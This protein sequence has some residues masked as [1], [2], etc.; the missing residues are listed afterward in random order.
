MCDIDGGNII[1]YKLDDHDHTELCETITEH[2]C[3]SSEISQILYDNQRNQYYME[4]YDIDEYPCCMGI[5]Y[6][7]HYFQIEITLK[8]GIKLQS[9]DLRICYGFHDCDDVL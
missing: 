2:V 8:N 7:H 4:T 5:Q 9:E 1:Y 3:L 6:C